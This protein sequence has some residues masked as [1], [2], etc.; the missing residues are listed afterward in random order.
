MTKH[1]KKRL[2]LGRAPL[3]VVTAS[4]VL[5]ATIAGPVYT[6]FSDYRFNLT[7]EHPAFASV[8]TGEKDMV[9]AAEPAAYIDKEAAGT[10]VPATEG[11]AQTDN[12]SSELAEAM[13]IM[14][15]DGTGDTVIGT[16]PTGTGSAISGSNDGTT[17]GTEATG[18]TGTPTT[19][20]ATD[21]TDATNHQP[22][23]MT[24]AEEELLK[25]AYMN[26]YGRFP[27]DV[28]HDT[29]TQYIDWNDNPT[30]SYYYTNMS[31]RPVSNAYPY[32][33]VTPDY[34][35]NSLFIGDSR[36]KGFSDYNEWEYGTYLYKV[37]LNVFNMMTTTVQS[38]TGKT[39]ILDELQA[40]QYENIYLCVGINELGSGTVEMFQ[41]KYGE[42][43][44]II[45]ENQPDARIIIM[46]IMYETP[47]YSASQDVYNN[48]NIN[49]KNV[50]IS[51]FANGEDI[52]YLDVNPPVADESRMALTESYSFDGVHMAAKHYHLWADYMLRRAY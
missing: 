10:A 45:R 9:Y 41:D 26:D 12:T 30:R 23:T 19:T 15:E 11:T 36:M 17:G 2:K 21:A 28:Y 6:Y 33:T 22:Y 35:E 52:F 5:I 8:L 13:A 34:F 27:Y 24:S 38:R 37:G 48:D 39:K 4:T 31:V 16:T 40:R 7:W 3:F 32:K 46:S 14:A 29:V 42:I 47:S 51:R 44:G 25:Q 49:A 1:K 50:A 18:T 20:T 43:L